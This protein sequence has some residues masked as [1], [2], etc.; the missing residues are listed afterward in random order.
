M[1]AQIRQTIANAQQASTDLD[2][3][4]SQANELMSDVQSRHFPQKIDETM[5]VVKSATS[6]LDA[7]AQQIHQTI[8]EASVPDEN[9][10]TPGVNIRETSVE[11]K[12]CYR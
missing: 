4:T 12:Y 7:S 11:Y 5:T 1:A 10:A 9:G 2:R 6:N 8:S 3:V